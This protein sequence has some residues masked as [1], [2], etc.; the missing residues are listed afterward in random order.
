MIQFTKSYK[1]TDGQVFGS[2]EQAQLHELEALLQKVPGN[3]AASPASVA[4]HLLDNK[5]VLIDVL[6]TNPNS[7][8]KARSVNGGSKR[9]TVSASVPVV[10]TPTTA[11]TVITAAASSV[12]STN[13]A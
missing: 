4:K 3:N 13:N 7:K 8:P 11:P 2:V 12:G 10:S 1:T 6:T 9:R 5:A